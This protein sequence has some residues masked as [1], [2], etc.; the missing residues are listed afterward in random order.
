M[1]VEGLG[2]AKTERFVPQ[3]VVAGADFGADVLAPVR[4]AEPGA[5]GA[6][7]LGLGDEP[8]EGAVQP[9]LPP[10]LD[11]LRRVAGV[12]VVGG[13]SPRVFAVGVRGGFRLS[14]CPEGG[15]KSV[16]KP[17]PMA[18]IEEAFAAQ[19]K[20]VDGL[21][22]DV[23]SLASVLKAWKKACAE[24]VVADRQKHA[25]RA[26]S[27][28]SALPTSVQEAASG[29]D[30]DVSEYLRSTEAWQGELAAVARRV[31]P[32]HR[33]IP[34]GNALASPPVMVR[35]EPARACLR[36]GKARWTRLRPS[37]VV[38]E[39]DRLRKRGEGQSNQAFLEAL[40][41]ATEFLNKR[42]G[43]PGDAI[44]ARLRDVYDLFAMTPGWAKENPETVF[45][46]AVYA[47]HKSADRVTR[48]QKRCDF[49][50]PTLHP[51]EKDVFT[52]IGAD[53]RPIRFFVVK[54]R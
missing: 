16:S 19:E 12:L 15:Y 40:W 41:S 26:V 23:K 17:L 11:R 20:L 27:I 33:L 44:S 13:A 6:A 35:A 21:E 28:A 54:F 53:G 43:E 34:D 8:S 49:E 48:G 5:E 25:D 4:A 39:L 3:A 1:A 50:G 51:P 10:D 29:W 45:A 14:G 47:L 42:Y 37:K 24:G 52:C 36:L 38:E 2:H 7:R 18:A 32:D 46:Q 30:F 31:A 9:G 22:R